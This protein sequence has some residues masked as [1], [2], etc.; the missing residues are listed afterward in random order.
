[1]NACET[2]AASASD[3]VLSAL[4]AV[5]CY[6]NQTAAA[7]FS[8]LF[9]ADGALLSALTILLTLYIAF[10]AISLLTGRSRIGVSALT[11]RMMTLGLVL[12][13]ATSWVAYQG[14]VWNLA[15]GAPDQLAGI[16]AGTSGSATEIFAGKLDAVFAAIVEAAAIVGQGGDAAASG[17]AGSMFTPANLM[18]IAALLLLLGTVGV[19]VTARIALAILLA[20]GPVFIVFVLFSGTRGLF[21]GWLRGVVLTG[22]VPLFVVLGG[23]LMMELMVPIVSSLSDGM[24]INARAAIAL[25]LVACVHMALMGI[26]MKVAGTIVSGWQVF[27][28]AGESAGGAASGAS[29]TSPPAPQ[30]QAAAVSTPGQV[31][32]IRQ[33]QAI[34]AVSGAMVMG[35]T[36]TPSS[37][38]RESHKT[39]VAAAT[40]QRTAMP[41]LPASRA[42]GIG[43][44]FRPSRPTQLREIR[45]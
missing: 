27:G 17:G 22:I 11:P 23:G 43:S 28:L 33:Q 1:M 39:I 29:A 5:D 25:F 45:K 4:R 12:T 8:R 18:W 26:V 9:G 20:L 13:F 19:L 10:F 40:D 14:F 7:G 37:T 44:R 32:A 34:A 24:A 35:Q 41:S 15:V 16:L 6:A 36:A 2:L 3:G 30:V 21:V 38:V 31:N 42:R